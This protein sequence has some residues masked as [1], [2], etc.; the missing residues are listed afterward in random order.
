MNLS[1]YMRDNY[2][3]IKIL[4]SDKNILINLSQKYYF[5]NVHR[6]FSVRFIDYLHCSIF[7]KKIK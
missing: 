3:I 5:Q 7:V 2:Y 1:V 6:S 4:F